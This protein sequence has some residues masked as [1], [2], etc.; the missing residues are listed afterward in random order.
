MRKFRAGSWRRA[1]GRAP[2]ASSPR[3]IRSSS[4]PSKQEPDTS[5]GSLDMAD[6]RILSLDGGGSWALIEIMALMDLFGGRD[7]LGHDV[8]RRFDLIASNSGGSIVLGALAK[9]MSLGELWDLFADKDKNKRATIF[10]NLSSF[11]SVPDRAARLFGIGARYDTQKN[12]EGLP[13]IP[14]AG[15]A[16]PLTSLPD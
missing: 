11:S 3:S 10:V 13:P 14:G 8:L 5:K 7:T 16:R 4:A 15:A 1:R 6:F 2:T 9:N 12:L